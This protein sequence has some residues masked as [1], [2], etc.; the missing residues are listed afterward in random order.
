MEHTEA[1]S[2]LKA[3][4]PREPLVGVNPVYQSMGEVRTRLGAAGLGHYQPFLFVYQ[5]VTGEIQDQLDIS[6]AYSN[7]KPFREP[8]ILG[9]ATGV[10][11]HHGVRQLFEPEPHWKPLLEDERVRT[12][13]PGTQ[14]WLG[15][16]AHIG[17]D[18]SRTVY[19]A[20]ANENYI[21]HD[22]RLVNKLL[23]STAHRISHY[24][25][26]LENDRMRRVITES[27]MM[28]IKA[29][30]W[31]ALRDYRK[32]AGVNSSE[33]RAFIIQRSHLRIAKLGDAFL[34]L[35]DQIHK[36]NVVSLASYKRAV[37]DEV[38]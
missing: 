31:T 5:N 10:F 37:F 12:V 26:P 13:D 9:R 27:A 1:I 11:W 3:V 24:F 14:L 7:I 15:M 20:D 32:L 29:G 23:T 25:V 33:E 19:E 38:A 2:N 8:I 28:V 18:L 30:R 21:R 34:T 36:N 22:Y 17:G 16:I 35:S 4:I 6:K